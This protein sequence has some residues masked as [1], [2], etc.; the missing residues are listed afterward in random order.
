[1]L[2]ID[3]SALPQDPVSYPTQ[4][5]PSRVTP[6]PLMIPTSVPI[7]VPAR[8]AA[9]PPRS[10]AQELL[11]G[12]QRL[13]GQHN[14]VIE[15]YLSS[16]AFAH[17]Y[18]VRTP[19]PIGGTDTFILK[20]VIVPEKHM[21]DEIRREVEVM[22]LLRDHPNIVSL[23]DADAFH[24]PDGNHEVLIL[25]ESCLDGGIISLMNTRLQNRFTTVEILQIF[26]DVCEG[27]SRMHS[28]SPP[29]IHMDLKVENVLQSGSSFKLCDFGSVRTPRKAPGSWTELKA[30]EL[31]VGSS[32]TQQYRAPELV[33]FSQAKEIDE[34]AD[35]WALGVFLYKICY[36]TTP[37]E[38]RGSEAVVNVSYVIPSFPVYPPEINLLIGSM[39]QA[40]PTDRPSAV[41]VLQAA[42]SIRGTQS[43]FFPIPVPS[44]Q[45]GR[46]LL[47]I[48]TSVPSP[49]PSVT[50]IPS[51]N[52]P[53]AHLEINH[54]PNTRSHTLP[55]SPISHNMPTL[56]SH[57]ALSPLLQPVRYSSPTSF[58]S[59]SSQPTSISSPVGSH[60]PTMPLARHNEI[61]NTYKQASF[62]P[63]T[64]VHTNY[65]DSP[66][67]TIPSPHRIEPIHMPQAGPDFSVLVPSPQPSLHSTSAPPA[68]VQG[69]A[70]YLNPAVHS[71][72]ERLTH[73]DP[74][75]YHRSAS[76]GVALEGNSDDTHASDVRR[77]VQ[78]LL[79]EYNETVVQ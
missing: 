1:M 56:Q 28:L 68:L 38:T 51:L 22:K 50:S 64:F 53:S 43:Q 9:Q 32:T 45:A 35:I 8:S 66:P 19:T 37:F 15:K 12:S 13:V 40:K 41:E 55:V 71:L 76:V 6:L 70:P 77:D 49:S 33:D 11:P 16:G 60:L 26:I 73:P 62:S 61:G 5:Y 10:S 14:V 42:H 65:S 58:V 75:G 47:D 30:L 39:L 29:L 48:I 67:S 18:Q 17:V 46:S 31:D 78:A 7:S 2:Q 3:P 36:F 72:D 23:V 34:K 52:Q 25:M 21:L 27:L 59:H 63:P 74:S 24:L 44:F 57:R 54:T 4:V 69:G 20:R 79:K